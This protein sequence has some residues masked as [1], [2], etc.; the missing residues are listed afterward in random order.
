VERLSDS[1]YNLVLPSDANTTGYTQWYYF[2]VRNIKGGQTCK[3]NL[4]NL[5]KDESSYLQGMKPFV[6][7][8]K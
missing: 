8:L 2:S 1:G 6:Y 4:V 7:S 3:F 5:I